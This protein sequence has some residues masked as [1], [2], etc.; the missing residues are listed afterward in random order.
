MNTE[1]PSLINFSTLFCKHIHFLVISGNNSGLSSVG[2]E[3][4]KHT[5]S[6]GLKGQDSHPGYLEVLHDRH[7][8]EKRDP[9][10]V[11]AGGSK[12][13]PVQMERLP[14]GGKL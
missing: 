9:K 2:E 10:E 3:T 4:K 1:M 6:F 8:V 11:S 7:S 12:Q 14:M 5:S 13:G